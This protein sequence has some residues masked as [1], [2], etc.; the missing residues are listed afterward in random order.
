MHHESIIIRITHAGI[1]L[2][3][4]PNAF[5]RGCVILNTQ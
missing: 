1:G 5:N 2:H 3:K 4:A